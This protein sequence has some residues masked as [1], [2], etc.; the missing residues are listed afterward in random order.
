MIIKWCGK[1]IV[2]LQYANNNRRFNGQLL[3]QR[4]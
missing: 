1:H 3:G 4:G 2:A